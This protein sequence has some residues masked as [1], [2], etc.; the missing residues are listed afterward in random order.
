M[1]LEQLFLPLH[2]ALFHLFWPHTLSPNSQAW[3]PQLKTHIPS[4]SHQFL[5][6]RSSIKTKSQ[7]KFTGYKTTN[8]NSDQ[9][10]STNTNP[11]FLINAFR[12]MTKTKPKSDI[13]TIGTTIC[14]QLPSPPSHHCSLPSISTDLCGLVHGETQNTKLCVRGKDWYQESV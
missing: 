10:R 14:D 4:Q 9:L 13:A 1:E 11:H 12:I 8:T 3:D 6:M 7:H 5:S 2:I